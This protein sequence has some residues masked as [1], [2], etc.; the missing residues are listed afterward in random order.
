MLQ[1]Q[2][3]EI[4]DFSGGITDNYI[5]CVP[6]QYKEAD[7][8]Q[9]TRNKKIRTRD[10]SHFLDADHPSLPDGGRIVSA[11]ISFKGYLLAQSRQNIYVLTG[12]GW[13]ALTGPTGNPVLDVASET[14][15]VIYSEWNDQLFVSNKAF[16]DITK[17]YIDENGDFQVRTGGL[18]TVESNPTLTGTAGS[19]NYIYAFVRTYTYMVGTVQFEEVS[20]VLQ[21]ECLNVNEPSV[22]AVNITA[23]PVLANGVTGNYD[24]A[25]IKVEIFR[26]EDAGTT[27]YK[28]GEVTNGTTIFSDTTSDAS[29]LTSETIYTNGGIL[30]HTAPPLAKYVHIVGE[31]GVYGYVMSGSQELQDRV[32]FS[33]PGAPTGVPAAFFFDLGQRITGVS[34]VDDTPIIFCNKSVWRING[35]FDALG[36]GNPSHQRIGNVGCVSAHSIV[37]TEDGI[38]FASSDGFYFTDGF[39]VKRISTEITTRYK[40]FVQNETQASRIVGA[41]DETEERIWWAVSSNAGESETN[42]KCLLYHL[43]FGAFTTASNGEHFKPTSLVFHGGNL[44]RGDARGYVFEHSSAYLSDLKVETS[45]DTAL[46]DLEAIVFDFVSFATSFGTNMVRKWVV[47]LSINAKNQTSVHPQISSINDDSA[48]RTHDLSLISFSGSI[49]WGDADIIWGDPSTVWNSDGMLSEIRHFPKNGLRCT[50]K[51]IRITNGLA[52]ITKS[53]YSGNVTVDAVAKTLTLSGDAT[54]PTLCRDYKVYVEDDNYSTGLTVTARNSA[55]VITVDDPEGILV[56]GSKAWIMKGVM[57]NEVLHLLS[58]TY[59]YAPLGAT[60]KTFSPDGASNA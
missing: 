22:N 1:L 24:T 58:Y 16:A 13:T 21:V 52:P 42:D 27:F 55:T 45:V 37:Q 60:H 29:L 8:F 31:I 47:K 3:L 32:M 43:K 7:N 20:D 35:S 56:S 40:E 50:L 26:T 19:K 15:A 59:H 36:G 46:W 53:D 25:S 17:I 2:P 4:E 18:P 28:V 51:Q 44:I 6:N 30:G 12:A 48:L 23:I 41:L 9:I 5:D 39:K 10:G 33:V 54:W 34:S 57:K 14:D 11:L 38:Y 49:V